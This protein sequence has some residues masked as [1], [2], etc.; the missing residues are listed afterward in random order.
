MSGKPQ[1]VFECIQD[2]VC[3]EC[4]CPVEVCDNVYV[5]K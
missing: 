1:L 4:K 5:I 3:H 2:I